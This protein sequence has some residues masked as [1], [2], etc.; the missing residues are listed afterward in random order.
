MGTHRL[1]QGTQLIAGLLKLGSALGYHVEQER[2]LKKTGTKQAVDVAWLSAAEQDFPLMIFEVESRPTNS[3]SNNP[4][5][6][7]G[8]SNQD[9]EKPLFFFHVFI[10]DAQ[11]TDRFKELVA[12]FGSYNYRIYRL[13]AGETD[14][15]ICD[16]ISQ[17]RRIAKRINLIKLAK[18]LQHP[19]WREVNLRA[20][21]LHIE[22]LSFDR[23]PGVLLP[24][25]AELSLVYPKFRREFIRYLRKQFMGSRR[26]AGADG[27]YGN[28]M[29]SMWSE[30]IHLGILGATSTP[31]KGIKYLKDLKDWQERSSMSQIGPYF[32]LDRDYD[33]F[34]FGLAGMLWGLVAALLREIPGA[35]AYIAEQCSI[36]L[37]AL[38]GASNLYS[39]H[40]ALWTLHISAAGRLDEP[41]E[42]A[43]KFI[44]KR[45]GV[46]KLLMQF[47][48]T[49]WGVYESEENDLDLPPAGL[50][51]VPK[52]E[53]F[54]GGL[55]V[56]RLESKQRV[57]ETTLL[58]IEGLVNEKPFF[59]EGGKRII[60]CLHG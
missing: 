29:G 55:A 52:L 39:F 50:V 5:K 37:R 43:R 12:L 38:K 35:I 45:G 33:Q 56:N 18:S 21:L 4:V 34:I 40:T 24:Q 2:R 51:M 11:K 6:I 17:H 9:F 46:T 26:S 47:P 30:P 42:F 54:L 48:Y 59:E 53:E 3:A 32:G 31:Q 15:L 49:N 36:V 22:R 27:V 13:S 10:S 19:A 1:G 58:A 23:E 60:Q 44:N 14:K 20:L 28:Y 25:Y 7:F 16:V 41:Y 8:K 57:R